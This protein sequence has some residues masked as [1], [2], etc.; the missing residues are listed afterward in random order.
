M[1]KAALAGEHGARARPAQALHV[2]TG[3]SAE[4]DASSRRKGHEDTR[5]VTVQM[6]RSGLWLP[7]LELASAAWNKHRPPR[8]RGFV[9][10]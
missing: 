7:G 4:V 5:A 8:E 3:A 2:V 6:G 9:A 10:A 1:R